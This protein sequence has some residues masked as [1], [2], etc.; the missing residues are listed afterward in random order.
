MLAFHTI[1]RVKRL[2]G[3]K[4]D[5]LLIYV[6]PQSHHQWIEA[7]S[8]ARSYARMIGRDGD[9]FDVGNWK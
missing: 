2:G 1:E 9:A 7:R 3:W 8:M 4:G 5:T 6:R